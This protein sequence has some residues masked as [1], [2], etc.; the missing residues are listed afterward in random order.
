VLKNA[1]N[2]LGFILPCDYST[3]GA[4]VRYDCLLLFNFKHKMDYYP[5]NYKIDLP[6]ILQYCS[7]SLDQ[8]GY[9]VYGDY[10]EAGEVKTF[11]SLFEGFNFSVV[12]HEDVTKNIDYG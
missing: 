11:T 5:H 6:T 12:E 4:S 9:L 2:D 3:T 7:H 8:G 10:F 1:E